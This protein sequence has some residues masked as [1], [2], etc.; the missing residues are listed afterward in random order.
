MYYVADNGGI[1]LED[2][3][4][5]TAYKDMCFAPRNAGPVSVELVYHVPAYSQDQLMAAIA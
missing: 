2:T 1:L 5:Y 4:P 3:Y